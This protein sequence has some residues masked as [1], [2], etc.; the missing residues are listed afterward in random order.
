M[1][2]ITASPRRRLLL[3]VTATSALLLLVGFTVLMHTMAGHT[4]VTSTR[5]QLPLPPPSTLTPSEPATGSMQLPQSL[6]R[7]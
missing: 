5:W 3:Q 1:L 7:R 2:T 6:P 4:T